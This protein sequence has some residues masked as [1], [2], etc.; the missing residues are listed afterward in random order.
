M[1]TLLLLSAL[2]LADV[3]SFDWTPYVL[4]PESEARASRYV[5][6]EARNVRA[7]D[8]VSLGCLQVEIRRQD[9][10]LNRTYQS[11]MRRLSHPEKA[12][13][14]RLERAWIAKRD[15]R[16]ERL[17]GGTWGG[18]GGAVVWESCYLDET[19]MR[20]IWLERYRVTKRGPV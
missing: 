16:C 17:G 12:R 3:D 5:E 10:K 2:A 19:I 9:K 1:N 14:R 4:S 7:S 13:L 15:R 20:T 8:N 18:S 11:V 6:C